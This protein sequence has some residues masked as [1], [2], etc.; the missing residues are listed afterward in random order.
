V[1]LWSDRYRQSEVK[2]GFIL[3]TAKQ[4]TRNAKN[5][6]KLSDKLAIALAAADRETKKRLRLKLTATVVEVGLRTAGDFRAPLQLLRAAAEGAAVRADNYS[7]KGRD[8]KDPELRVRSC[9]KTLLST[10]R[11]LGVGH[12]WRSS[13]KRW[14]V[15]TT[16]MRCAIVW[17]R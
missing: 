11:E 12:G 10:L 2:K 17:R 14:L 13:T 3:A 6:A 1:E 5:I 8:P 16:G 7:T 15:T 9:F 4:Q